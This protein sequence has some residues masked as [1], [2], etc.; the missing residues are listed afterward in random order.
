MQLQTAIRPE[1]RPALSASASRSSRCLVRSYADLFGK[2][3]T[4]LL[5]ERLRQDALCL[6]PHQVADLAPRETVQRKAGLVGDRRPWRLEFGTECEQRQDRVVQALGEELAQE[7]QRGR[8][9]PVKVFYDE[10]DRST[11]GA[12]VQGL[13]EGLR[14]SILLPLRT[15]PPIVHL[16]G[17]FSAF[18]QVDHGAR[19]GENPTLCRC[20]SRPR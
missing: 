13:R 15:G 12:R 9:H 4:H 20:R 7:L 14:H 8:V 16:R 18:T 5:D 17:S 6:L 3:I 1:C 2:P 11:G 19:A 10:Q